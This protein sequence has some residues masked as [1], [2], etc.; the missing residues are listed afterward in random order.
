MPPSDAAI[1]ALEERNRDLELRFE[2]VV[3]AMDANTEAMT[4]LC[5]DLKE[6]RSVLDGINEKPGLR[7]RV[8]VLEDF[9]ARQKWITGTIAAFVVAMLARLVA[10]YL[11]GH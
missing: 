5:L 3:G 10:M 1:A 9:A 8:A 4:R 7:T 11:I 2:R 6:H